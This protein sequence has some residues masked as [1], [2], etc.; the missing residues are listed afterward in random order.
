MEGK[1][2]I[3]VTLTI[4]KGGVVQVVPEYT[5]IMRKNWAELT[6]FFEYPDN[7][8]KIIYTTN[9]VEIYHRIVRKFTKSKAAFS[10]DG[11]IRKVIYMNVS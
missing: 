9:A 3:T 5:Q 10:M 8:C 2:E 6:V 11:S 4:Y 7:I 1:E